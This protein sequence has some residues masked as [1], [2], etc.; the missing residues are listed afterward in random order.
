[1]LLT[2][3]SKSP[4]LLNFSQPIPLDDWIEHHDRTCGIKGRCSVDANG[5]G[6]LVLDMHGYLVEI[7]M[8]RGKFLVDL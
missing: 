5:N 8:S 2:K 1:M 4:Q 6:K 7:K 3:G